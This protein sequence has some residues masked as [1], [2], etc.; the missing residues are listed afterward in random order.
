[1]EQDCEDAARW[2]RAAAGGYD[3]EKFPPLAEVTLRESW[4]GNP[5][6]QF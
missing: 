1:M 5:E 6:A 4:R 2:L 3:E